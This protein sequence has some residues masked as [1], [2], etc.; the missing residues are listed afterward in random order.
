MWTNFM[1]ITDKHLGGGK[2]R[3]FYVILVR[4]I[5]KQI[6]CGLLVCDKL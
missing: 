4:E 5:L 1:H 6:G 2:T 3:N